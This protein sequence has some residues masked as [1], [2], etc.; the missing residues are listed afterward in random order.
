MYGVTMNIILITLLCIGIPKTITEEGLE[1]SYATNYIG[2]FHLTNLL[3]GKT[4]SVF[5]WINV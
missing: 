2:P 5:S 3:L 1:Y 4:I